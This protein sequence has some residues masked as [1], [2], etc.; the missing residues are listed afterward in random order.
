MAG[1]AFPLAAHGLNPEVAAGELQQ[2]QELLADASEPVGPTLV[3]G[4]RVL[5][6]MVRKLLPAK[7]AYTAADIHFLITDLGS[8][9]ESAVRRG[10]FSIGPSLRKTVE[11]CGPKIDEQID[12]VTRGLPS[13]VSLLNN[14]DN[15]PGMRVVISAR[16]AAG[17]AHLSTTFLV[18]T[19]NVDLLLRE[20]Q[21]QTTA[22]Q[23]RHPVGPLMDS[24]KRHM[25]DAKR[26]A[27][28]FFKK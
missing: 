17:D 6:S 11:G 7:R 22:M 4:R 2:E 12:D 9:L 5:E 26:A 28:N 16:N 1:P 15:I 20:L 18:P 21:V 8:V 23:F 14:Y 25:G 24:I 19:A 10:D 27:Q 3:A 13:F